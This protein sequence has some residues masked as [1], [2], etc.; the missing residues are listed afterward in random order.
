MVIVAVVLVMAQFVLRMI[1]N[2]RAKN[3]T[4]ASNA[5]MAE[6]DLQSPDDAVP[7][8]TSDPTP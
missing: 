7:H 4:H 3:R 8:N 5:G 6:E 1:T 2:R